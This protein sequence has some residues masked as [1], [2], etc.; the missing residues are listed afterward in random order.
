VK[1]DWDL[2]RLTGTIEAEQAMR[3]MSEGGCPLV[4]T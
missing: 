2:Y 3:P 4:R 1:S